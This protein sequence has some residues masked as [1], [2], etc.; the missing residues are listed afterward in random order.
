LLAAALCG[1]GAVRRA[2]GAGDA[3]LRQG[4]ALRPERGTEGFPYVYHVPSGK[5]V[6][7]ELQLAVP[8]ARPLP[9]PLVPP[10]RSPH[11]EVLLFGGLSIE[12]AAVVGG[13]GNRQLLELPSLGQWYWWWINKSVGDVELRR[14]QRLGVQVVWP[15]TADPGTAVQRMEPLEVFDIPA[16]DAQPLNVWTPWQRADAVV[17]GPDARFEVAKGRSG[18]VPAKLPAYPF[19]LRCRAAPWD[20]PLRRQR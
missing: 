8:V 14:R 4:L 18:A 10:G 20:T 15:A 11:M 5:W 17:D 1:T 16:I 7:Q 13:V 9:D 12:S 2:H 3:P 19:E 6:G